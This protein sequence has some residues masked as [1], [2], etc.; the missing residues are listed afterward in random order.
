MPQEEYKVDILKKMV[1]IDAIIKQT[2]RIYGPANF[3]FIREATQDFYF[4]DQI[5]ISKGTY[6]TYLSVC[7]HYS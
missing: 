4:A 2:L 1:Y 7:M 5:P 6:L 3:V